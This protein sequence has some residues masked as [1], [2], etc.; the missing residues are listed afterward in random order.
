MTIRFL[1]ILSF[2]VSGCDSDT[3]I[4]IAQT[5]PD[6][7]EATLCTADGRVYLD[8]MVVEPSEQPTSI[9]VHVHELSEGLVSTRGNSG[10]LGVGPWADGPSGLTSSAKG[11]HHR[12]EWLQCDEGYECIIAKDIAEIGGSDACVCVGAAEMFHVLQSIEITARNAYGR[13]QVKE[14]KNLQVE[15]TCPAL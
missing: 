5:A 15:P 14:F 13:T 11:V 10:L 8:V 12:I 4:D 2:A 1:L 7:T 9:A 6:I 3:D